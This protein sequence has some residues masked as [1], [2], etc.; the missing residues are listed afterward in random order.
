MKRFAVIAAVAAF[1]AFATP[2]AAAPVSGGRIEALVGWDRLTL[3][4][5]DEGFNEDLGGD[6][7]VAGLGVGYDFPVGATTSFGVDLEASMT[8]S[9]QEFEEGGLTADIDFDRDL[10]AGARV[11]TA[12][13]DSMNLFFRAGYTNQRITITVADQFD[14]FS[15]S[16]SIEGIRGGGG[17][18]FALGTSAYV[19]AEYRYSNYEADVSRHQAVGS[20]GFRF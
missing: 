15:E 11:T 5:E 16:G 7:I 3:S 14:I 2:A 13:S 1:G 6:G 17:L 9:G 4:L 19:G 10:Y 20:V 12:L 8:P 18:Q